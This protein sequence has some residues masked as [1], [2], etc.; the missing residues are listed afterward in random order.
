MLAVNQWRVQRLED[1]FRCAIPS[2]R[3]R[4]AHAGCA[5]GHRV[6]FWGGWGADDDK[7][8]LL[9]LDVEQPSEKERR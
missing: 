7:G 8:G 9:V 6:M 5:V 1:E 4:A 3:P 2:P